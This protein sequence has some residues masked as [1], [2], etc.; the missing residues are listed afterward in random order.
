MIMITSGTIR[1][2]MGGWTYEPWETTFYPP[3][4]AK[5]RQLEYAS[6]QVPTIE[7]NGTY[8]SGFKPATFA[9][10]A[11][12]TPDGFV[13]TL[14]GNRF[15]TNR[16]VLAEAAESVRRFVTQGIV[17]LGDKLGPILWQL[18]PTKRF[19]ADDI[20]AFLALLPGEQDGVRLRHALEVR[21]PSFA[22]PEFVALARRHGVAIVHAVHDKYP[23]IAD[24]SADFVYCRLQ[25]GSDDNET[26]YAAAALDRWA[27][28]TKS[29]A[30]GGDPAELAHADAAGTA[31]ARPRDVFVYFISSG[32]SRAPHGARALMERLG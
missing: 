21:H 26:C 24:L 32:K 29:W 28:R 16:R 6:R 1:A 7:V 15:V 13:F 2:G 22:V 8:Y 3:G 23:E 17:E 11:A 9:K 14:K 12:E 30:A 20:E 31:E 4:L 5:A 18:A 10:W 27:E 25:T 19:D